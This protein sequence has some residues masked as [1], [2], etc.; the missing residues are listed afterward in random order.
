MIK[1]QVLAAR[2]TRRRQALSILFCL[3]FLAGPFGVLLTSVLP[4]A[5]A[6]VETQDSATEVITARIDF[7]GTEGSTYTATRAGP[8]GAELGTVTTN[9]TLG[10]G[11]WGAGATLTSVRVAYPGNLSLSPSYSANE[12]FYARSGAAPRDKDANGTTM[13]TAATPT[14]SYLTLA[15]DQD[16]DGYLDDAVLGY[17]GVANRY[18]TYNQAGTQLGMRNLA[19]GTTNLADL[20]AID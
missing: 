3:Q 20:A 10:H 7:N 19:P 1:S 16:G 13:W 18:Y 4:A 2:P 14:D 5:A 15:F 6:P 11:Y 12:V 8:Q 17:T 9:F